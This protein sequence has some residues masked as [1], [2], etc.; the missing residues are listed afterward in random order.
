L[1]AKT[2]P[3]RLNTIRLHI[4]DKETQMDI[5]TP[6]QAIEQAKGMTFETL[7]FTIA[8]TQKSMKA[9]QE[10]LQ[11]SMKASQEGLQRSMKESQ[12]EMQKVVDKLSNN[13]GGINNTIGRLTEA[14]FSPNILKKFKA[15]G[16]NFITMAQNKSF[17]EKDRQAAEADVFLENTTHTMAIEI[18]TELYKSDVDAHIKRITKIRKFMTAHKDSRK[19]LGAIAGAVA[20]KNTVSYAQQKGLFV[21]VLSGDSVKIAPAGKDFAPKEW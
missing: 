17:K 20:S 11:K 1:T 8:E 12:E 14:M 21:F 13:I 16:Y 19:I 4:P 15:L 9:S 5:L 3:V 6:D 10:E 2:P 7:W 18:K